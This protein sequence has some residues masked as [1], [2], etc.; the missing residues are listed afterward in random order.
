M[1]DA[2]DARADNQQYVLPGGG[3]TIQRGGAHRDPSVY[4]TSKTI[5]ALFG[6][7]SNSDELV[8][9]FQPTGEYGNFSPDVM[10]DPSQLANLV[11]SISGGV[12]C[13]QATLSAE[14]ILRLYDVCDG[15]VL[16]LLSELQG[17][18]SFVLFDSERRVAVAARNPTGGESL[19]FYVDDNGAVVITNNVDAVVRSP[20]SPHGRELMVDEE[21]GETSWQVVVLSVLYSFCIRV[22]VTHLLSS[23]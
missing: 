15:N 12:M 4:A 21:L 11:G 13:D 23:L 1:D 9:R 7:L 14:L 10:D 20:R 6:C 22:L 3:F 2:T 19:Y 17:D 8:E 16:L 18:Y 5:V